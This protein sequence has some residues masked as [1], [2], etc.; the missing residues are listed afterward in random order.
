[1]LFPL[2]IRGTTHVGVDAVREVTPIVWDTAVPF[3]VPAQDGLLMIEHPGRNAFLLVL[4]HS[5]TRK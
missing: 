3:R 1:M 2:M 4:T 5:P